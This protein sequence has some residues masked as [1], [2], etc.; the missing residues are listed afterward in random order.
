MTQG[1]TLL[2]AIRKRAMTYG[3]LLAL[4]VS[5]CPWRRLQE[6]ERHLKPGERIVRKTN[7]RGLVTLR[8][9]KLG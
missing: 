4:G 3:D 5:T 6:A 8:A 9:V 2:Q 7:A 1:Q